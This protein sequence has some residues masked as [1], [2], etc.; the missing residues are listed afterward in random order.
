[1][2]SPFI[3]V[4]PLDSPMAPTANVFPSSLKL[5]ELPNKPLHKLS[6]ALRKACCLQ[7]LWLRA[8]T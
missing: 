3:P 6:L 7:I 4:G 5:T 8:N 2:P 1:M